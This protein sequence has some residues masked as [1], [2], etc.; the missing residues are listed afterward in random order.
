MWASHD[1][2][3]RTIA[4]A[5]VDYTPTEAQRLIGRRVGAH[6]AGLKWLRRRSAVGGRAP[7]ITTRRR[8][9]WASHDASSRAIAQAAVDY[10]PTEAQCLI[11]RRVGAHG[12][13]LRWIRRRSARVGERA[14]HTTTLWGP[15]WARHDASSRA[16]AQAAVNYTLTEVKR[17]IGRRARAHGADLKWIRRRRGRGRRPAPH[18]GGLCGPAKTALSRAIAQGAPHQHVASLKWQKR[19]KMCRQRMQIWGRYSHVSGLLGVQGQTCSRRTAPQR[20][21]F[22]GMTL[23]MLEEK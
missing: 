6:G 7:H 14:P 11:G 23:S 3:S 18:V 2:S 10:I 13:G 19:R 22:S 20:E 21:R 16:I 4:Q 8:P 12:A 9:L 15:L 1:A 5:A 17:L